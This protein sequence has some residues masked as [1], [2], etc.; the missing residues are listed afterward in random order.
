MTPSEATLCLVSP[1]HLAN[2]PRLIKEADALH[3]AGYPVTVVSGRNDPTVDAADRAIAEAAGWEHRKVDFTR[4]AGTLGPEAVHRVARMFAR[5]SRRSALG[6]ALAALAHHRAARQLAT[7]AAGSRA[8]LY[9]GHTVA[10]LAAAGQAA[11]IHRTRLG[12]DAEDFHAAETSEALGDPILRSTIAA[13]ER[14]WL[15]RCAHLTAASPLIG[16][17]Y[18][19]AYPIRHPVT[20]L[21]VFPRSMAP[22]RPTAPTAGTGPLRLY[23]Y[24]QTIGPGRGLERLI[25]TLARASTRCELTLRGRAEGGFVGRLRDL[26]RGEGFAGSI[27]ALAAGPPQEMA[28]LCVGYDLGLAIEESVPRNRDLCLT[29]KVFTYLLAGLPVLL[30][31]TRAQRALATDLGE[32]G[33]L[34]D[35]TTP[36]ESAAELDRWFSSPQAVSRARTHA[37]DLGARRFNWDLEQ[38]VLLDA[39]RESLARPAPSWPGSFQL[40]ATPSSPP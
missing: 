38:T 20:L 17:A 9:I 13:I 7:A 1:M 33:L 34:L 15:P 39:V 24:S 6:P 32:A 31:P 22:A 5:I 36:T 4:R 11:Q 19:E 23:W 16:Q 35:L 25:T 14:F 12:F 21:N 37:W 27:E 29:N 2:N 3:D 10:G 26:A 18:V 28:R 30:S 8:D 40:S